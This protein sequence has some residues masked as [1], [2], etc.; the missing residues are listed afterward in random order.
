MSAY[1]DIIHK[2][3][4]PSSCPKTA[5]EDQARFFSPFTAVSGYGETVQAREQQFLAR[6]IFSEYAKDL[7]ERKLRQVRKQDRA[8]VTYFRVEQRVDRRELGSFVTESGTVTELDPVRGFLRLDRSPI[9]F[10]DL[11][12]IRRHLPDT[13]QESGSE[14]GTEK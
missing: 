2:G 11:I 7:L 9:P 4:P 5:L 3:R 13:G 1:T 8:S 14:A 10:T 12:D 6:P